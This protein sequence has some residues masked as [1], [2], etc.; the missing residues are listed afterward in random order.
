MRPRADRRLLEAVVT[1]LLQ[2][3]LRHDPPRT[4]GGDIER[5]EIGPGIFKFE[6]EMPRIGDLHRGNTVVQRRLGGATIALEG[7]LHVLRRHALAIVERHPVAQHE[8]VA[9]AIFG[10]RPG[11][12]QAGCHQLARHRLQHRIVQRVVE[13]VRRDE[14]WRLGRIEP[15]WCERDVHAIG[16]LAGWS[17]SHRRTRGSTRH[18]QC[19]ECQDIPAGCGRPDSVGLDVT[20]RCI[21]PSSIAA[22]NS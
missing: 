19:G 2:I 12:C 22:T 3:R 8:G 7:E 6:C 21:D 13:H 18:A 1:D 10:R 17:G 20:S 14:R 4:G 16:Q 15:R 11:L 5:Q 9:H